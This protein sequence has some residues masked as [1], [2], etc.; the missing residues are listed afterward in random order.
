[1]ATFSITKIDGVTRRANALTARGQD[2]SG[3]GMLMARWRNTLECER[4]GES[5]YVTITNPRAGDRDVAIDNNGVL[6]DRIDACPMPRE[7]AVAV[8]RRFGGK[9]VKIDGK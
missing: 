6:L 4:T 1:M 2:F 9:V 8:A 3:D 7:T 5:Y